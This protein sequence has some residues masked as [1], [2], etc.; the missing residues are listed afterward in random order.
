MERKAPKKPINYNNYS[1]Y[2]SYMQ[3]LTKKKYLNSPKGNLAAL[4]YKR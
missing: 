1:M 3:I 2:D 4:K